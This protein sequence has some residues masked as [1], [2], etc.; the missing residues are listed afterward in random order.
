MRIGFGSRRRALRWLAALSGAAA[1]GA[2]VAAGTWGGARDAADAWT[3][4]VEAA[5]QGG[6]VELPR[7]RG[8]TRLTARQAYLLAFHEA[9]DAA[10]PEHVLAVADRLDAIGGGALAS[11]VRRAARSLLEE[12]GAEPDAVSEDASSP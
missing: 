2:G 1:C 12:L 8:G 9:Q 7:S 10:D 5:D 11:H 4:L 3:T 6:A